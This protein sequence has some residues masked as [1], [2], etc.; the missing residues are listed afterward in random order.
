MAKKPGKETSVPLILALVFFV[1]TTITF[2]VMWYMQFSEQQAKDKAV[3]DAK[4]SQTAAAGEAA[5]AKLESMILR[6]FLGVEE[7]KDKEAVASVTNAK[8]KT[9]V[10][11]KLKQINDGM[12]KAVGKDEGGKLP[13]ELKIWTAEDGNP[14]PPPAQGFLPII[15]KAV[16]AREAAEKAQAKATKDY[17][18]AV[19]TIKKAVTTI[20][21]IKKKFDEVAAALPQ[22]FKKDLE[23]VTKKFDDRTKKFIENEAKA[24]EELAKIDEEK[25]KVERLNKSLSGEVQKAQQ[26]IVALV[27]QLVKKQDTFQYDEPQGKIVRRLSDDVVEIDLGSDSLVRPGLT[28]SVLPNDYPEKGR[29]SRIREFR[30]PNERGEYK[31]V[32]RFVEKATIEVIEV[33]SPKRSRARITSE[34]ERIRDAIGPGDLLYNA[35]WRKGAA[36]HIALIGIFDINGDG[37]DDIETVV[38]DLLKMGIPVDAYYDLKTRKWK[39]QIDSQ[40]RFIIQGYYPIVNGASDPLVGEKS[41]LRGAITEGI[42]FAQSKGGAQ[43]VGFRDFFPRMGY[44]VKMDVS[45]D[46]I[47]QAASPY[48]KGVN[49]VDTPPMQQ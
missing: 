5:D 37:T 33:L 9:F 13:D 3:D 44:K 16:L 8:Q 6:I 25:Q 47:N 27:K 2:G 11:T 32:Q 22:K 19:D 45:A 30:I 23:E 20:D 49:T 36:D 48:L 26:E 17:Q 24:R 39:G 42:D 46:K 41:K 4:K 40:T 29:Q 35:A 12:A 10:A 31:P 15:G 28:F 7:E 43:T 21:D 18:D 1:L 14:G 38:R 34:Y